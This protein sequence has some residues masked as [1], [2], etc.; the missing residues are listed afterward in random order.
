MADIMMNLKSL[1]PE[2]GLGTREESLLCLKSRAK[3]LAVNGCAH[4]VFFCKL[5]QATWPQEE[6]SKDVTVYSPEPK[7]SPSLKIGIIGGGHIGKQLAR[8][9]IELS[10]IPGKNLQISTRRP[11]T[12]LEF[13]KLGVVCFYNNRQLVDQADVVFLCCLPCHLPNICSEIQDALKEHCII[14]SL[15]T[16]FPLPRLKQ[17]LSCSAILRPQYECTDTEPVD[18]WA[19]SRAVVEALKDPAVIQATCPCSPTG[20]IAVNIKWL[21]AVFYAA[22]NSYSWQHLSH[23]RTLS[24]LNQVCF[25]EDFATTSEKKPFFICENFVNKDF[26]SSLAPDDTFPWFDLT[27]V[28]LKESPLSQLLATDTSFRDNIASVYCNMMAVPP[29]NNDESMTATSKKI[30]LSAVLLNPAKALNVGID[31]TYKGNVD[32]AHS[33]DSEGL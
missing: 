6:S 1:Q 31:G 2:Y 14:Y 33:S 3:G 16:A 26:A 15:V 18:V 17:L 10:G 29:T 9:L 5:L 13:Q 28:Q 27:T 8:A 30:S 11:E 20:R 22:L 19:T 25:T 24:L 21:A 32:D 7:S 12:L 4:A 23:V